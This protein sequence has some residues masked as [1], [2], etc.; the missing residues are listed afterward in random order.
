MKN[1]NKIMKKQKYRERRT[2]EIIENE[3]KK[4]K[5]T[6]E[7][8]EHQENHRQQKNIEIKEHQENHRK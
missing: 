5:K 4:M 7:N 6:I 3:I 8:E 1:I 2:S